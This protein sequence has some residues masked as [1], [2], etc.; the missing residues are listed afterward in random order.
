[1]QHIQYGVQL[2]DTS[3]VNRIENA[4]MQPFKDQ[5]ISPEC[6]K[7]LSLAEGN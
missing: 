1:M 5:C 4:N 7:C 2:T 3:K 6:Y